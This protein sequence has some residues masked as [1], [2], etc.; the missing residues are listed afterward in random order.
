MAAFTFKGAIGRRPARRGIQGSHRAGSSGSGGQGT[1]KH[2][3]RIFPS[4]R[5]ILD[6]DSSELKA[7][8]TS[9][10]SKNNFEFKLEPNKPA[11]QSRNNAANSRG[12]R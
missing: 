1:A 5:N 3:R 12:G 2:R 8:V 6:E 10:E 7:T 4:P 11:A 9:D